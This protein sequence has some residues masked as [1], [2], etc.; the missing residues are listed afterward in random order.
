MSLNKICII[1]NLGK[2]PESKELNNG[3][4]MTKISVCVSENYKG[5]EQ[6][7]W[8]TCKAFGNQASFIHRNAQT[9]SQVY[10]EGSMKSNEYE[11]KTYWDLMIQKIEI[12]NGRKPNGNN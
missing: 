7:Q 10:V 6:T 2:D 8:F 5:E 12:L 1:G 9:G 3:K 11:G 4:L